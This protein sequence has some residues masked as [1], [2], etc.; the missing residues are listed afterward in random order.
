M[1]NGAQPYAGL[2]YL[3]DRRSSSQAG[4]DPVGKSAWQWAL[5]VNFFSLSSGI[6]GR[7]RI[8]PGRRP[9]EPE[10]QRPDGNVGMRF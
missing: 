4:V 2:S 1:G 9:F 7:H 10:E 8:H 5:G 3:G 6:N